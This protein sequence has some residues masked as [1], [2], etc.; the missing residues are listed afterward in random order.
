MVDHVVVQRPGRVLAPVLAGAVGLAL[1]FLTAY[2]QG[3]LPVEVGS[4]ANSSG[5]WTLVA[6]LL[7]LLATSAPLAALCGALALLGLLAG[8][9]LGAGIMGNPSSSSLLI[10]W[11]LAA[12]VV[13]PLLGLAAHWV[14]F[15]RA[16]LAAIGAGG[17]SGV[18]IGEGV[19][20]GWP[21]SPTRRT[22]R[23]GGSRSSLG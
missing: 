16:T 23:T 21:T 10:F 13:G 22:R 18:L 7:A 19:C 5:S 12:V 11:G 2:A 1:G 4:L 15:G 20:T 8:Y 6:F 3:W 17:L 14:R 9:I